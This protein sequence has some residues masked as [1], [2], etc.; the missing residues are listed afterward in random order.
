MLIRTVRIKLSRF[1]EIVWAVLILANSGKY[2]TS[3]HTDR[4]GHERFGQTGMLPH[5]AFANINQNWPELGREQE[6]PLK[7]TLTLK[8]KF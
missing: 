2:H 4:N 8:V 1:L 5:M 7:K 3:C 6:F